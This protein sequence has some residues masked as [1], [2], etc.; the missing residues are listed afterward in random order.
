[1][2]IAY[3]AKFGRAGED[4][5][6]RLTWI[7]AIPDFRLEDLNQFEFEHKSGGFSVS[8][9]TYDVLYLLYNTTIKWFCP[10]KSNTQTKIKRD[11]ISFNSDHW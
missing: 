1:M 6:L 10:N 7:L 5:S 9:N 11:F 3:S 4:R 8:S 2:S